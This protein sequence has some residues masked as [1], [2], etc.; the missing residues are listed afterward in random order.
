MIQTE[1]IVCVK[2]LRQKHA[3]HHPRTTVSSSPFRYDLNQLPY[4]YTVEV[5][6]RVKGL[7]LVDRVSKELWTEVR[8]IVQ[9][10][11]IKTIPKKN[12]C[13]KQNGCRRR[14]YK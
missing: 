12:K 8:N 6:N 11:G 1:K 13:K 9:E 4:G 5:M 3:W 14:P 7:D 10:T 2:A